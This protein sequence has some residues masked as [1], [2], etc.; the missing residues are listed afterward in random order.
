MNFTYNGSATIPTGAGSYT[1]VGTINDANYQGSATGTLIISK[2]SSSISLG[3]LSQTYDGSAKPA[4][5]TTIPGGMAVTFTYNGSATI[6]TGA[7]SY[8]VVGTIN[9]VNYQGSATNTLVIDKA[10]SSI[11]LGSLSQTYDGSA[12]PAT[13]TTIPGGLTVNFTY[14]GSA[15]VPTG[16]G[17]YTVVGTINDANYQGSATNTLV[18]D[19]ASSSISLGSLSQTYDGSAKPA[20]ATTIPG[21]LTVNFTYDGSATVPT[22]AGSYTVVGTINDANYQGSAT[23]TLVIDKASSSISLGSLSQTYDGSAKPATAT[24]IPGGLTVNFT[25]DGSATVPTGAGSYTVVGTINDANYQGSATNTLVIDKASSSISLGSLSQ[26]YDGSAKPATATTIPGGLTV[27]FTYDGSA[28]V[29]TGAGSYTVVG[30]INDANYQG[31]ATNT[32]VI[33]KASSSISLGSLS[34]TYDGSAKPATATTIPGGLTVNFTYDGSATVPTGAGSYT[35]VGTINDANYQGSATNTLVI[36]KASSSISLGSLSQTYDGSAK[37]ATATTIPGGLTVNFTYD[38]SATVPTG[39]GSYTVVGTINDAN[40]QGSA[41]NTLVIDKASSSISLGSLSQTYD[42]SAKPATATTIPGGLTVNFTYDGSAT[43]PTG[44]GS[45]TV[46][47]TIND[48]NYQGSATNTLVINK[49]ILTVTAD[50]KT[51]IYGTPNPSLTASYNGFVN[52]ENVDVL[53][54]PVVLN[55]AATTMCGVGDYPITASGAAAA[56]YTIQ[57]VDGKLQVIAAPQLTGASVS[58]NG[59]QQ[60]VVRWQTFA[61]QT[62]QLESSADLSAATW[63]PVGGSVAGTGTMVSVTNSMSVSPQCFFRVQVQ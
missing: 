9:D 12:K 42:G 37:P 35:V 59:A 40:Y 17:S 53:S 2:A 11:S 32:L 38:G 27:N 23:N 41:T 10:S 63:T 54:S 30:T 60:F 22:G 6:P 29:P 28:T 55:T 36:D 56:N 48:A 43:V 52:G 16:A 44:A 5:A 47:G 50:A 51:K 49:V 46:V 24:T 8:T 31:S 19:K 13:A 4:T 18:I 34:Q 33:D 62:Y 39:A 25:Y 15:T 20:T 61:N 3:S 1:V 26:T 45:Y 14:D 57:Y 21:G 58:V 7:G